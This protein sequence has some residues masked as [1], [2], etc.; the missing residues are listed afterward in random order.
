LAMMKEMADKRKA[1]TRIP[2]TLPDYIEYRALNEAWDCV[3]ALHYISQNHPTMARAQRQE[4]MRLAV[5]IAQDV[6]EKVKRKAAPEEYKQVTLQ[7][8]L[9]KAQKEQI[10]TQKLES[11]PGYK[12]SIPWGNLEIMPR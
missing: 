10:Q 11:T 4:F 8:K 9:R 5:T 1:S 2:E 3:S 12:P 6:T 7:A